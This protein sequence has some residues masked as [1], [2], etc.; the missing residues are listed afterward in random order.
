MPWIAWLSPASSTH[1]T[2]ARSVTCSRKKASSASA[3][4]E[5]GSLPPQVRRRAVLRDA[6]LHL[7]EPRLLH[8]RRERVQA[9]AV[10]VAEYRQ[11]VANEG[12]AGT[13]EIHPQEAAARL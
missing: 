1:I 9:G 2:C 6:R 7:R 13:A 8:G 3:A 4:L 11:Q 5:P 10:R 12:L